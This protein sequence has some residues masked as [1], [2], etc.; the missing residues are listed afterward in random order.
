VEGDT[1]VFAHGHV[2]RI[3]SARWLGQPPGF[4]RHLILS[5][6]TLSELGWE[7]DRRSIEVWNAAVPD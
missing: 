1:L 2:L 4:G 6:A 3:L 5:P 7:T